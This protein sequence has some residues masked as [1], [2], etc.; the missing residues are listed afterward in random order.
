VRV[1]EFGSYD[2]NG[3][4][5]DAF[6]EMMVSPLRHLDLHPSLA[7]TAD[8]AYT[9]FDQAL[10]PNVDTSD[11]HLLETGRGQFGLVTSSSCMEHDQAFWTSFEKLVA[12][13]RPVS[14]RPVLQVHTPLCMSLCPSVRMCK[15]KQ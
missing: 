9:G 14:V 13:L 11:E 6:R 3:N 7:C 15:C 5:R 10:G 12:L 8:Y 4:V 1:L 2:V